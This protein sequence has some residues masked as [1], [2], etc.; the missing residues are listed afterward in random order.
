LDEVNA[1]LERYRQ[2]GIAPLK[3]W[4]DE[5]RDIEDRLLRHRPCTAQPES[6]ATEGRWPEGVCLAQ[7]EPQGPTVMEILELHSWLDDEWQANNDGEDLPTLDFARAVLA[8]W[9]NR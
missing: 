3:K 8:R 6:V 1:A 5:R 7:P 4:L 2:A 9:G